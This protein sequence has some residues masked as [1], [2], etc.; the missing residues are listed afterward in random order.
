M[1]QLSTSGGYLSLPN[2]IISTNNSFERVEM[3]PG[4]KI[5]SR[6]LRNI[7]SRALIVFY[8]V[9]IQSNECH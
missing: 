2:R 9:S 4:G 6:P 5:V 7:L 8:L 3:S 1:S